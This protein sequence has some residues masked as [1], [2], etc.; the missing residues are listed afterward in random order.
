[1]SA[2]HD[3]TPLCPVPLAVLPTT[4]AAAGRADYDEGERFDLRSPYSDDG[5]VDPEGGHAACPMPPAPYSLFFLPHAHHTFCFRSDL[6]VG[7]VL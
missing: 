7:I 2:P 6:S 3:H 1:M 5:W 4:T